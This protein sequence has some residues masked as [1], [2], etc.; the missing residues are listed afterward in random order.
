MSDYAET[1]IYVKKMSEARSQNPILI[2]DDDDQEQ[3]EL[4]YAKNDSS[5]E[6]KQESE[7]EIEFPSP[8]TKRFR[9]SDNGVPVRQSGRLRGSGLVEVVIGKWMT[10]RKLKLNLMSHFKAPPSSQK[11]V[12]KGQEMMDDE[13]TL[14]HFGILPGDIIQLH[15]LDSSKETPKSNAPEVGFSGTGLLPIHL[16][17]DIHPGSKSP[18]SKSLSKK[19][20]DLAMDLDLQENQGLWACNACT[21]VNEQDLTLCQICGSSKS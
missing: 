17:R 14:D 9:I 13:K 8:S 7:E 19:D 5:S 3:D 21:F 12:L 20:S 15:I 6:S 11:L 1:T 4:E 10:L 16:D 2:S 18:S